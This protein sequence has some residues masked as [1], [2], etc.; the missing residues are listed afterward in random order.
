MIKYSYSAQASSPS[1]Y[2]TFAKDHYFQSREDGASEFHMRR[3][4]AAA[5]CQFEVLHGY[6]KGGV[7]RRLVPGGNA[8]LLAFVT[9][10]AGADAARASACDKCRELVCDVARIHGSI[11]ACCMDGVIMAEFANVDLDLNVV[12]RASSHSH[13]INTHS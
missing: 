2:A 6:F 7:L 11:A 10:C 1:Q 3:F 4:A 13:T 9:D 8:R 5:E 12:S